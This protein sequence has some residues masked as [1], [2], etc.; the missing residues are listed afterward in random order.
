[1]NLVAHVRDVCLEQRVKRVSPAWKGSLELEGDQAC[2]ETLVCLVR[3]VKM[4][5]LVCLV[6]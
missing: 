2:Q 5:P 1:M 6:I 3:R 4:D